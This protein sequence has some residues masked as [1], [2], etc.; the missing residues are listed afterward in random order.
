LREWNARF[1]LSLRTNETRLLTALAGADALASVIRGVYVSPFERARLDRLNIIR[2]VHATT[3][4]EGNNFVED[5]VAQVI[6][7]ERPANWEK[8]RPKEVQEARNADR[9]MRFIADTL[10]GSPS[11]PLTETLICRLNEILTEGLGYRNHTPGLYRNHG[12][13]AGICTAGPQAGPWSATWRYLKDSALSS[14]TTAQS[15]QRC[16][17]GPDHAGWA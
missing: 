4:I 3:A 14:G 16:R 12:V 9:A 17:H 11:R 13:T 6:E 8:S 7:P 5:Q 1:D 2:T 15:V 10:D